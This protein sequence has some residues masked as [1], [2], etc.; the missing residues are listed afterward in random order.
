MTRAEKKLWDALRNCKFQN[1]KFR[2]Q[3]P[4]GQFI[5]DF[6]CH[7]A[8]LIIEVDGN[9]HS[10]E[11]VAEHDAGRT[12]ELEKYNIKVMRFSNEAVLNKLEKVLSEIEIVLTSPPIAKPL[13]ITPNYHNQSASPP[14]PLLK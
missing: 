12:F 1:Y 13:D 6:Y 11:T 9:I 8:R 10:H 7:K 14:T 2:R 4:I 5:A 3:H